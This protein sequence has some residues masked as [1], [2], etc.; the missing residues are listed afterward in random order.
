MVMERVKFFIL[1]HSMDELEGYINDWLK[2]NTSITIID[3]KMTETE[4]VDS[5]NVSVMVIYRKGKYVEVK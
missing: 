4:T 3:I 5:G 2:K 1:E